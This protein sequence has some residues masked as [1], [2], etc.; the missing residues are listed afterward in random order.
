[1]KMA[2]PGSEQRDQPPRPQVAMDCSRRNCQK[3]AV[4]SASSRATKVRSRRRRKG[5]LSPRF[6]GPYEIIERVGPV[7]YRLALPPELEKIHNVFHVSMLRRYRSDPS[8][9]VQ[10]ESIEI[11]PDLTYEEEPVQILD[12]EIKELRNKRVPLVKVLWRNHKV[13]EATWESEET[14]R[15]QYPQLH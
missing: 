4:S 11:Q 2:K 5:K 13:E 8:H 15:Q 14:M 7:A 6:I 10:A 12:R 9:R 1:M 3:L